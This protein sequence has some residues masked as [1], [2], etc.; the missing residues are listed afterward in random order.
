[1]GQ[2]DSIVSVQI[3]RQTTVPSQAG[4]GT[5]LLLGQ[6]GILTDNTV[7]SYASFD[8]VAAAFTSSDPEYGFASAFF[9]QSKKSPKI[10]IANA[11]PVAG[12]FILK[13]AAATN[14]TVTL[15]GQIVTAADLSGLA[16]ALAALDDVASATVANTNYLV[17]VMV[18]GYAAV[19][20]DVGAGTGTLEAY[21]GN[22]SSWDFGT[23]FDTSVSLDVD[24]VTDTS[25]TSYQDLVDELVANVAVDVADGVAVGNKVYL[26]SDNATPNL[27]E[28][29]LVNSVAAGSV[30]NE[31]TKTMGDIL[32]DLNDVDSDFYAIGCISTAVQNVT[33]IASYAEATERLFFT[34]SADS[35]FLTAPD[36]TSIGYTLSQLGLDRTVVCYHSLAASQYLD[37]A[38]A[39]R[40][41]PENPGSVDWDLIRLSLVTPD[42]LT[43]AQISAIES[44]DSNY[45]RTIAGA[46]YFRNGTVASGEWI[47]II[48]GTDWL[49]ARMQERIFTTLANAP[50]V[51]YTNRGIGLIEA[52]VRA[53]L[54]DGVAQGLL[55]ADPAYEVTVPD[56]LTVPAADKANRVLRN[57][58]FTATYAGA[59]HKVEIQG[60]IGL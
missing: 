16:T 22:V 48:R 25:A 39:G 46:N 15:N 51:P 38:I 27:L 19:I 47:D 28:N 17:V 60:T 8:E 44:T 13:Q 10:K 18:A 9:G 11:V 1:M 45:F 59:I 52:D 26:V 30:G 40:Q 58:T 37:A 5:L 57:V 4:F 49:K 32:A 20:T 6:S 41:L 54:D 53:Q 55:A 33:S 12:S 23:A 36:T 56:A 7:A 50:K 34:R 3:T 29:G 24:G 35:A 43:S 21:Q 42:A 14:P 2:L 31:V